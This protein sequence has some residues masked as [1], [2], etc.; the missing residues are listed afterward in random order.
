VLKQKYNL[1]RKQ[2]LAIIPLGDIHWG[3]P[4]TNYEWL[5]Y[6]KKTIQ[7]ITSKKRIYLMGDLLECGTKKLANSA[8]EQGISLTDQMLDIIDFLEPLKKDIVFAANGNHELRLIKDFDLDLT[9]LI[10]RRRNRL[11]ACSQGDGGISRGGGRLAGPPPNSSQ[12]SLFLTRRRPQPM[13]EVNAQR[14]CA[15]CNRSKRINH[16][17]E[18]SQEGLCGKT[19]LPLRLFLL[20]SRNPGAGSA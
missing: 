5:E 9:K 3:S 11:R 19:R 15:A 14:D 17:A 2:Q 16:P 6:W 10:S 1:R 7:K 12:P 20:E 18:R 13:K 8:F 4:D